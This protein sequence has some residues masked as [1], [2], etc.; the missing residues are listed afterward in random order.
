MKRYF[1]AANLFFICFIGVNGQDL[2][3]VR[4]GA[5]DKGKTLDKV[6]ESVERKSAL[7]FYYLPHWIDKVVVEQDYSS[8]PLRDAL[9]DILQGTEIS[10]D[11]FYGYAIILAKDPDHDLERQLVLTRARREQ[12][13]VLEVVVG[14]AANKARGDVKLTGTIT[15]GKTS[16]PL[17]GASVLISDLNTGVATDATGHYSFVVP[18][19][20]HV[21]IM[22]NLNFDETIINA[23]VYGPGMLDVTLEESARVL[24]EVVVIDKQINNTVE[25]RI[26]VTSLKMSEI[27]KL[28]TFL[29]EVDIIRQIQTL[30]GV[31]SVG[32][33]SSGFNVRGGGADQNLV[34]Y[35]KVQ[36]FNASHV[37]GFF[38]SFNSEAVRDA[39]FYKAGIPVEFGGRISSV[40]SLTSKE[41]DFEKWK[42][43]GGLGSIASNLT[44]EG[45]LKK[46]RSSIIASVRS[47]YS[48]W[49][50]NLFTT[51]VKNFQNSSVKFYDVSLKITQK[52]GEAGK[53]SFSGYVSN[54]NFTLPTDTSFQWRNILGS[55]H[56]DQ[57]I[58]KKFLFNAIIGYGQYNY[59]VKDNDLKN[60]YS[61]KYDIQYPSLTADL[62]W[63]SGRHKL[64][65]GFMSTY[66]RVQPPTLMPTSP[67]SSI[68][69][70]YREREQYWENSIF[71]SDGMDVTSRLHVD[72]GLRLSMFTALGPA[73]VYTYN[74]YPP[75]AGAVTDTTRYTS[76]EVIKKYM[77][78]EPRLSV[79]Y[80]LTPTLSV[81][82]AVDQMYQ[83]LHLISNSV[84][85]SPI[86]VWQPSNSFF[87]PQRSQQYSIGVFQTIKSTFEASVEVYQKQIQNLLDFKDGSE[88]ILNS[89]LETALLTGKGHGYGIELSFN[90]IQ[91][92]FTWNFNYT[93]SRTFREVPGINGG[94]SYP[95]NFDQPNIVNL[96][97]KY[98][99]SKRIFFTGSFS[100]R[101]GRPVTVP[102]SYTSIDNVQIVNFSDRNSYRIPDYHRLDL[103]LVLEGNHKKKKLWD[104]TWVL[105]FYNVYGRRNVYTVF[106]Q[107]NENGV[108]QPYQMSLIGTV[109]PSLSYRFK[110]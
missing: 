18:V 12:K 17:I 77:G 45:P 93:Y 81:K 106:Y 14:D 99:L 44:V 21:I 90:K 42:A 8:Q 13:S 83:Y 68:N 79:R 20:D 48:D 85:V 74:T 57:A 89:N 25:N 78:P 32:E 33:V 64:V 27:K 72:A 35:D 82:A 46:N 9:A 22:R 65:G 1:L 6:L 38:S 59:E 69:P 26:G 107:K 101:T 5:D 43:T 103:A 34:L 110:I 62:T 104:G 29:G 31:T 41:G 88:L 24:D 98:G 61:L 36:I 94:E 76:G 97:W 58:G 100:Y 84:S 105:S 71:V 23:K 4:I 16:E 49:M 102:Y 63:Q 52:I 56:Y 40:L 109:V 60:A 87:N 92:R 15:S 70:F 86:D 50:L 2:S 39:Q 67:E 7:R 47:S 54:D 91:G 3:T 30:P 96:N 28:P 11:V 55:V 75:T 51:N 95:S 73:S 19:G 53:I 37:F 10:F 66:Y 108:L 80:N